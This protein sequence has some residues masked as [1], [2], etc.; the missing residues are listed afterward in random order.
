VVDD[1]DLVTAAIAGE[2]PAY[3]ALVAA[4]LPRVRAVVRAQLG[5]RPEADDAVQ[6]AF[7]LAWRRL[8]QLSAP[9]AFGPWLMAIA[10][11]AAISWGRK[12]SRSRLV[13]FS[14]P[15]SGPA[16]TAAEPLSEGCEDRGLVAA[17]ARLAPAHREILHLK[18]EA[19]LR[20][21]EIAATLGISEAAVE[22]RLWRA[23]QALLAG[24]SGAGA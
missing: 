17:L 22:K 3:E 15:A 18:Y 8:A 21:D 24:L 16:Q 10:R 5:D 1:E 2:R 4:W 19:G 11:N 20:Y 23:R 12:I 9:A 6:E 7:V 13:A 14:D